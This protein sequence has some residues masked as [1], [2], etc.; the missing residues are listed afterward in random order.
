MLDMLRHR[1]LPIY[2]LVVVLA[3][4]PGAVPGAVSGAV[5]G[6]VLVFLVLFLV[7]CL[8]L[9]SVHVWDRA[10]I[11]GTVLAVNLHLWFRD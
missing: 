3:S 1:Y 4:F 10:Y 5:P 7:L 6:A 11:F 8:V 9:F 2:C